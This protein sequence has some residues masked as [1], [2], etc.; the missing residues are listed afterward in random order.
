M[1]SHGVPDKQGVLGHISLDMIPVPLLQFKEGPLPPKR[2]N[3]P[4]HIFWLGLVVQT[5]NPRT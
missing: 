5:F 2:L 4:T 3:Y 1:I